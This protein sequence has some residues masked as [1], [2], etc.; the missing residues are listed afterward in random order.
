MCKLV[1]FSTDLPVDAAV[2]SLPHDHLDH[3][4]G[5]YPIKLLPASLTPDQDAY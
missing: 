4:K 5:I 1:I 3:I 2:I